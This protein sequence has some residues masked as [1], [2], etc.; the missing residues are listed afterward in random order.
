MISHNTNCN[1]SNPNPNLNEG[2]AKTQ[3]SCNVSQSK[4]ALLDRIHP[5]HST[6][7][8]VRDCPHVK[9][10]CLPSDQ[11]YC[12]PRCLAR[13]LESYGMFRRHSSHTGVRWSVERMIDPTHVYSWHLIEKT[14]DGHPNPNF[15][16]PS[17]IIALCD[18]PISLIPQEGD[19]LVSGFFVVT[20]Q[21]R[22]FWSCSP[23]TNLPF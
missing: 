5:K 21:C 11:I 4:C 1:P 15:L 10:K 3:G 7:F 12:D 20:A 22:P 8:K 18:I 19:S 6:Q 23:C 16:H 2:T 9:V 14:D 13:P 17:R